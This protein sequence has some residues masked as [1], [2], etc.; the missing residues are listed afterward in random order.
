[1]D[2]IN[3]INNI[4]FLTPTTKLKELLLLEHIESNPDTTQKEMAKIINAA[5]SMV[6]VYLKKYEKNKYIKK[7]YISAK[8]VKYIITSDGLK[9]KKFLLITYLHELLK[10]YNLAEDNVESF[11]R[12]LEGKGY[13][14]IVLYGAGEVAEIIL[15]I[16]KNRENNLLEAVAVIDDDM[17]RIN[18]ELLGLKIIP[19]KE[20]N[21]YK[22]D[23]VLI[24][25]YAFE[26]EIMERLKEIDYPLDRV[27]R[28]FSE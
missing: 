21:S 7:E 16:L 10:L 3:L 20:I 19:K 17:A 15:G 11:L 23:I 4:S 27:K 2:T 14:K 1:M 24:T 28:F 5:P 22:H 6:N 18:K 12:K 25:S 26:D 9:R 8:I 13:K